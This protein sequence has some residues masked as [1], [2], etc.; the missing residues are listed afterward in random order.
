M[1]YGWNQEF[2]AFRSQVREFVREFR[3]PEVARQIAELDPQAPSHDPLLRKIRSAIEQRGWMRMCWPEELGGENKSPWYQWILVEELQKADIPYS[4][5]TA[6]MIGPA[7]ERFGTDEQKAKYLPGIWSGE[8]SLALG[9]SEPNAGT[10]LASLQTQARRDGDDWVINGQKMWTSG[11]HR[12]S[13]VWLA[14][15][16]DP[17]APKHRGISMFIVPL[18][19]PGITVRPIWIMSGGRT[20][21]TF[22]EDVRVPADAM[23][24]DENRGWYIAT[25][26]LDHERVAIG[27]PVGTQKLYDKLIEHVRDSRPDVLEDRVSRARLAEAKV[28]VHVARAIGLT[29]AA[30]VARHDTPTMEAS[31]AKVWNSELRYRL[32]SLAMSLL[33]RYGALSAGSEDAPLDGEFD[34]AFRGS[35]VARFGGGTNEVQRNIIA[36]RGLGLPRG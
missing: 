5:G 13:H 36:E 15:R 31:M 30:I 26:A 28:E 35:P 20:N 29:N 22:Y 23:I 12:S 18:G 27:T 25:V 14:V 33:G 2:E 8:I 16:T 10:D 32:S 1:E 6:S 9:Y 21:E 3:T 19:S 34:E 24:G 7:I 11:A 17:N 4:L